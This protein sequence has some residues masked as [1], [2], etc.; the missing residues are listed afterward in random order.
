MYSSLVER[1][2]LMFERAPLLCC[3]PPVL[4]QPVYEKELNE[5]LPVK[6][7]KTRPTVSSLHSGCSDVMLWF[8]LRLNL[9][10][11]H[12][13]VSLLTITIFVF[14]GSSNVGIRI[15]KI[16]YFYGFIGKNS[17]VGV[18]TEKERLHL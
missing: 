18:N 6:I 3:F 1:L 7:T 8:G 14:V 17:L 2:A 10:S 9:V 12:P 4:V 13:S 11:K 16:R 5:G 15:I